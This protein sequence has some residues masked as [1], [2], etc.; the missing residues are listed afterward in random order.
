MEPEGASLEKNERPL[1]LRA[2]PLRKAFSH[3]VTHSERDRSSKGRVAELAHPAHP[4]NRHRGSSLDNQGI[5]SHVPFLPGTKLERRMRL[6]FAGTCWFEDKGPG[7]P[8]YPLIV[9]Y[10]VPFEGVDTLVIGRF[11]LTNG[12]RGH[13]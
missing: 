2:R 11:S 6:L 10:P 12:R 13:G 1:D 7:R 5:L 3:W 9:K 8:R 4:P